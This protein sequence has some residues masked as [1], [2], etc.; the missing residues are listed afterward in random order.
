MGEAPAVEVRG[1]EV[2][3]GAKKILDG[4]DVTVARGEVRV[5]LGGSGCGK[6]T[7]L[8]GIIGLAPVVGGTVRLLG[9]DVTSLEEDDR[10]R[11]LQRVGVLFQNG[12]LLGSMTTAENI[13]LPLREHARVPEPVI[14]ELV[15]MKLELV[16][17]TRAYHLYP[18]ELSG[19]M[20]KRVALARAMVLDPDVLFCDEPSAGLD[21]LSSAELDQLILRLRELFG[22]A[23]V[24]VT[25]ELQSIETIADS[26]TFLSGGKAIAEGP[27]D[28]I[29]GAGIAEVDDFFARRVSGQDAGS[30]DLATLLGL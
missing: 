20:R 13:A 10:I 1:L 6:S 16:G 14:E 8:K 24:I 30:Q 29:R 17:L 2:A 7:L 4:V 18:A 27:M 26:L 9:E 22:M 3:Y 12:A 5:I 11:H 21:P 19:G 15:R 28:E 23:V 25:H